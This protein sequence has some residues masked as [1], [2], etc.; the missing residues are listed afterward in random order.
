MSLFR[1][2]AVF[3]VVPAGVLG[4]VAVWGVVLAPTLGTNLRS[5]VADVH[6]PAP[7]ALLLGITCDKNNEFF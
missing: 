5:S 1:C 4:G 2:V 3:G 7:R 6:L